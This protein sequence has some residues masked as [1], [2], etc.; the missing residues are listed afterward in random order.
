M[1]YS[2]Q[3]RLMQSPCLKYDVLLQAVH[4]L[5]SC[6]T[7]FSFS[8]S[9]SA[10][11]SFISFAGAVPPNALKGA[12]LSKAA[13][14]TGGACSAAFSASS[15]AIFSASIFTSFMDVGQYLLLELLLFLLKFN[16]FLL[17]WVNIFSRLLHS[18]LYRRLGFSILLEEQLLHFQQVPQAPWAIPPLQQHHEEERQPFW[19]SCSAIFEKTKGSESEAANFELS[20]LRLQSHMHLYYCSNES[21]S[22]QLYLHE[23]CTPLKES[24]QTTL[25][26]LQ[27][28]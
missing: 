27:F 7:R 14:P 6:R 11:S 10:G 4:H 22:F 13:V 8:S 19:K 23:L 2:L 25:S 17:L 15:L 20:S 28:L 3:Y 26:F 12:A 18:L 16:P 9:L 21:L 1:K 24:L 5:R